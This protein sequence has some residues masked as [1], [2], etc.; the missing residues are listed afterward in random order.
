MARVVL[1]LGGRV[2]S[3]A[4]AHALTLFDA[5][6]EVVVVHGAGPQITAEMEARG[7][8]PSFV[9]GRRVTTPEVLEVV[10]ATLAAVNS[11]VCA[12]LGPLACGLA[13]DEIGLKA[14]RV[15]EL[16][17]VGVPVPCAP[18]AVLDALAAGK[19]PVIAPLAAG[20]LN[21]NADEA[22]AAL[23]VGIGADRIEFVT[24]V[25]GVYLGD[26]VVGQIA[27]DEA[28]RML[29]AGRFEGGIVP[30]LVAAVR[31]AR[32]GV[33]AEIGVTRIVA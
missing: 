4:A 18:A 12:A 13:G 22:A 6:D 29:D 14:E 19:V 31:A 10:R 24:D 7:I 21:V 26:E 17:L 28:D 27:A 8:E 16:G 25:P 30:K 32:G 20:P 3:G 1:K 5:G 11:Q 33:H 23:A 9:G 15:P 2:A